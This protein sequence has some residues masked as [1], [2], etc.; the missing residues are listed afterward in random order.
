[1]S[2]N[3][4]WAV[5]LS[6]AQVKSHGLGKAFSKALP[7]L[8]ISK[9]VAPSTVGTAVGAVALLLFIVVV[10]YKN[11]QIISAVLHPYLDWSTKIKTADGTK[12][13]EGPKY[14]WPHGNTLE[15]FFDHRKKS[16]EWLKEYG[17][18]YRIWAG[19]FSEV[20]ITTPEDVANFFSDASQHRKTFTTR[21]GWALTNV[22]GHAVGFISGDRWR[23]VRK[24]V[25]PLLTNTIAMRQMGQI[26]Q[27]GQE[28]VETIRESRID[29]GSDTDKSFV[30]DA[31][32]TL[33]PF[34][35]M[36]TSR[37][38]FGDMSAAE[39]KELWDIG[40]IFMLISI[41]TLKAGLARRRPTRMMYT[42]FQYGI[43]LE[44][45]K[46]WKAWNMM[47]RSARFDRPELPI[48]KLWRD[49]ALGRITEDELLQTVA[50]ATYANLDITA[51]VLVSACIMLADAVD[52]QK[53]L[54]AEI[55]ANRHD[56]QKY[57]ARKDTLLHF[58]ILESL[59]LQPTLPFS[60]PEE[61][62]VDKVLGGYFIPKGTSVV[63]DT[64]GINIRN[65]FWGADSKQYRPMRFQGLTQNDLRYNLYTFGYGSRKCMGQFFADKQLRSVLM[66]LYDNYEVLTKDDSKVEGAF[67][68]D[69]S[70]WVG[71]F[72]VELLLKERSA[73]S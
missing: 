17:K 45:S 41:T 37:V 44:Y 5:V 63:S 62:T 23:E 66:H 65:P 58:I 73:R 11:P 67:K 30:I 46:R 20:V 55:D 64:Y 68:T 34:P 24:S 32:K 22:M 47:M 18:T 25:D 28:F 70:T 16:D 27:S 56:Q 42:P 36:E 6:K 3:E 43:G 7:H 39:K 50:E 13:M 38:L 69:K 54:V 19:T 14:Q 61:A 72:D 8:A 4:L 48:M 71:M 29:S 12:T 52:V 33:M 10:L 60:F 21:G 31:A 9:S 2:S 35:L 57:L 51:H 1:M 15:K 40:Q 53:D 59:R 49:V 26:N